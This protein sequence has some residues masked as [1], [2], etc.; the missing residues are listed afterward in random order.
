MNRKHALRVA[1]VGGGI[2][3][4]ALALG[5]IKKGMTHVK[6]FEVAPAFGEI[7]A[8]VSFGANAVQAIKQ[9]G[10]GEDY[11]EIADSTSAPWQDV[12]FEWRHAHD[13]SLIGTSVA[14]GVGQSSVHRAD[15]IDLL[16][17]RLPQGIA[18]LGRQVVG[19]EENNNEVSLK[20]SD[21]SSY[22]A[23]VVIAADGIKSALRNPL[24]AAA[25]HSAVKPRFTGTSAFRGLVE[26]AV[27]RDAYRAAALDEHLLNVPQMYLSEDA[28]VLTFPVKKGRL[29]NIVA[30]VSDRH[31]EHPSWPADMPWVKA[32]SKEQMLNSFESSGLAVKTLLQ[33]IE[34]PTLWA[35]HDVEPLPTYVHGRVALIGDAAH[36]MLPHQGAGAGQG[37]EDAYFLAELLSN[38]AAS[39][40]DVPALLAAYDEVR[41][42]RASRVQRTSWE[43]GELYEYKN[44]TVGRDSRKLKNALEQRL[45]WV[46]QHSLDDEV[47]KALTLC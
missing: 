32:A 44:P 28:H 2:A 29:I 27:L 9:L 13:A 33:C 38:E 15:F 8:G 20:F 19:Y 46:W 5:L 12:W 18:S 6:L 4:T 21:G 10:I 45:D 24:L 36:A 40:A 3:G 23:D 47:K 1:I 11:H 16:A 25:G 35:L 42:E 22:P 37:L 26:T 14:P 30:F 7:G 39:A 43:A 17:K 34:N 41:R 31:V